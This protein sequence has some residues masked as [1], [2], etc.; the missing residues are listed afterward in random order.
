MVL[1]EQTL[2]RSIPLWCFKGSSGSVGQNEE[3]EDRADS[4]NAGP[5]PRLLGELV[6]GRVMKMSPDMWFSKRLSNFFTWEEREGAR[7][8]PCV[9]VVLDDEAIFLGAMAQDLEK[10]EDTDQELAEKADV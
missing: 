6:G 10:N 1:L 5:N 9:E 2:E 3:K 8:S 7:A 4:K